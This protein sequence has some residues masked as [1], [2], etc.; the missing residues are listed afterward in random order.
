MGSRWGTRASRALVALTLATY[1][2]TCH[3]CGRSGATTGDH[4]VPRSAGG[5]DDLAN[6]RPAHASCNYARGAMPLAEW[7]ARHPIRRPTSPPSR[8]W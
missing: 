4:I 1:G 5:S 2:D 7:R 8:E 6:M 3:L